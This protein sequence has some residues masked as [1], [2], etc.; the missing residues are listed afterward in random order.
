M[1]EQT[2]SVPVQSME[3]VVVQSAITN[4]NRVNEGLAELS[5]RFKGVVYD[6]RTPKGMADAK[7]ARK[8]IAGPRIEVEKIRKE[9]KAPILELGRKLDAEANRIKGEL[10]ALEKPIDQQITAEENRVEAERQ[11]AIKAEQDRVALIRL[12]ID[13]MRDKLRLGAQARSAAQVSELMNE[14]DSVVVD[15]SFQEF[16]DEAADIKASVFQQLDKML[17]AFVAREKEEQRLREER[18]ELDRLRSE[19][20]E[21]DRKVREEQARI[22]TIK[23]RITA[24][25][26]HVEAAQ[27][28][29]TSVEIARLMVTVS[30]RAIGPVEFGEFVQEACQAQLETLNRLQALHIAAKDR[31]AEEVRLAAERKRQQDEQER[32]DRE[33]AEFERRQQQEREAQE[34]RARAERAAAEQRELDA[35]AERAR[36]YKPTTAEMVAVLCEH[37]NRDAAVIDEW[38]R[39]AFGQQK[40]KR[41]A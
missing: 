20:A 14:V 27:S 13:T 30:S 18:A 11:A 23:G 40:A 25:R 1:S 12:R 19:Q 24:I 15:A 10:E 5:K 22:D 34:A 9:A 31:E 29:R 32:L 37:Y 8:A 36:N 4:M 21:R 26:G 38:L 17:E 33:R 41:V 2:E 7:A 3:L 35:E 28:M 39:E 6:V 16:Q